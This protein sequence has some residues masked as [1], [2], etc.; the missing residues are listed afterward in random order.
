MNYKILTIPNFDKQLKKIL[1]KYPSFKTDFLVFI[2]SLQEN[3]TQGTRIGNN[4]FKIRVAITAK[5]KGKSGG[6]R[7][8]SH[9]IINEENIYLITIYDKS[10]QSTITDN[11]LKLLLSDLA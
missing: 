2:S 4:C 3:P 1:K 7:I 10:D 6:A 8:V 9:F 5:G 11:E